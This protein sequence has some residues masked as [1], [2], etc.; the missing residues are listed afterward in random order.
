M[1]SLPLVATGQSYFDMIDTPVGTLSSDGKVTVTK[2][3]VTPVMSELIFE[4]KKRKQRQLK[5]KYMKNIAESMT[6]GEWNA[7]SPIVIGILSASTR[8]N[9]NVVPNPQIVKKNI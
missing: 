8:T 1:S 4:F 3:R 5:R 9:G 7:D 2:V 6:D